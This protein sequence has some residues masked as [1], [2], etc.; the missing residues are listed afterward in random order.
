MRS[1]YNGGQGGDDG[2]AKLVFSR[3]PHQSSLA[4]SHDRHAIFSKLLLLVTSV[5]SA[6]GV[7]HS[8]S[9]GTRPIINERLDSIVNPGGVRISPFLALRV[10]T[11]IFVFEQLGTHVHSV[12]G[13][14]RFKNTYDF[15]DL[16]KSECSTIPVQP[17][18]SNYWAV[19][20]FL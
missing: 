10:L 5:A 8:T 14:S 16:S 2:Q 18:K 1:A 9:S 13:G 7:E 6:Q 12:V 3:N 15:D 19:R 11:G 20:F 4:S 17:D